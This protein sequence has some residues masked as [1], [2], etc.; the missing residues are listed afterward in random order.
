MVEEHLREKV[1]LEALECGWFSVM[2]EVENQPSR[3][4]RAR[5]GAVTTQESLVY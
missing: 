5:A 3:A 2:G 1:S 4:H